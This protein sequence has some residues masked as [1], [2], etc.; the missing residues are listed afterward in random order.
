ME[1]HAK[2]PSKMTRSDRK[3]M[4]NEDFSWDSME[5]YPLVLSNIAIENCQFLVSFPNEH[6]DCPIRHVKLPEGK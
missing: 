3:A 5:I 2:S 1:N 6:G 4:E